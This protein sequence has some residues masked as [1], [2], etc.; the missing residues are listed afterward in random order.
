VHSYHAWFALMNAL[1]AELGCPAIT[2]E[3]FHPTWGQ[4]PEADARVF[5]GGCAASR[6]ESWYDARLEEYVDEVRVD[7]DGPALF[8]RLKAAGLA[9]AVV[10]NTPGRGARAVLKHAGLSPTELVGADAV[11]RAKPAPDMV[12]EACRRLGVEPSQAVMVGDSEFDERAAAAAE[13]V[14]IPYRRGGGALAELAQLP[15][16][17][18]LTPLV[19]SLRSEG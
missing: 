11:A 9:V 8:A 4:G 14:F 1:A 19:E 10:T 5:F 13:V 18:G 16:L 6:V 7:P 3:A 17:L 2:I 15:G 12:L